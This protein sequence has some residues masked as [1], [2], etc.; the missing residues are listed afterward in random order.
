[1][2][3]KIS[4][5]WHLC[6]ASLTGFILA[7]LFFNQSLL[8]SNS[9]IY[10]ILRSKTK[11]L[12]QII[13]YVNHFYFGPVNMEEIMDGAFHGL[14]EEL[15][16]HSVYIPAKEQDNIEELFKGKFQGIGIEFDI[17]NGYI[18]VIS[19]VPDSPSDI[20]GLM[21]GDKI[22]EI[23][24]KDAY[25]ITKD[26]VFKQ[27]RGEKGTE[28]NISISRIGVKDPFPVTIIRD[29]IPIYSVSAAT[30]LDDITGYI[31]L[32]RFSATT[33]KE[34]VKAL[35][36]LN[37]NGMKRLIFDLRGNSG[38]YLEQAAAISNQFI[39]TNDTLVYTEGK[40]KESNQV[41]IANP[42]KGNED[43]SLIVLINRGSASASEIVSGAVQDLDRGLVVG[44]TS[45]GKGL[46]QR[47][48]PLENGGAI[49]VT[50]A[51]YY[52][53]SGRLIQRPYEDGQNLTYYRE[54]YSSN[55]EET[56][57]SL[58]ALRPKYKTKSGRIVYGGGGITPDIYIPFRQNYTSETE[59]VLRNPKRPIF[60][61]AS[62]YA[63]KNKNEFKSF[64]VFRDNWKVSDKLFSDFLIML[65]KDSINF[66]KDSLLL[67]LE[68]INNQIKGEIAGATWGKDKSTN[69]KLRMDNQVQESFD[70]FNKAD[71]FLKSIN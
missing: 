18:T 57:D 41:F 38:G 69:I 52:T 61:F 51:R 15:D 28:V 45:F 5:A 43:F 26:E 21:P 49:R 60:N 48:L 66:I 46:V 34:V 42:K 9:N 39:K 31:S 17:L 1:M 25:G 8:S 19:P 3:T 58:K 56:I 33:E 47:Q 63:S 59:K 62:E 22:I 44:E 16:P 70:H 7:M 32:R 40:I 14:M 36:R 4:H 12:Q 50:I 64:D 24:G 6:L 55:R 2:K 53:P 13:S 10:K 20:V 27:L 65:Q 68:F 23:D 54:L 29:N 37:K 67:D 30:M 11:E 71:S 35:G